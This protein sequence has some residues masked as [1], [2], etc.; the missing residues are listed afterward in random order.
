MTSNNTHALGAKPGPNAG[1]GN[2]FLTHVLST[3]P[4]PDAVETWEIGTEHLMAIGAAFGPTNGLQDAIHDDLQ[5]RIVG[6][7]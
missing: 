3:R 1:T 2:W 7:L 6:R 5:A 4:G